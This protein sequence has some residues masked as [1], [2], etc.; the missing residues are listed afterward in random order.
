EIST[1]VPKFAR[2]LSAQYS[3]FNILS[4]LNSQLFES[5]ALMHISAVKSL[6]SALCQLSHQCMS[7]TSSGLGPTASQKLG[8]I[9]FSVE[10]MISILVNNVHRVEPFWDQVVSHFLELA[11]NPNPHLKN[12]ALDALDQS[13]SAVLGSNRFQNYKQLKSLQTSQEME[14][15]LDKLTSLECSIISPLK[16]LYFSTQSVDVRVGSLKILLHVLERYGEK[17][18]Y[19]WPNILE[20]LRYVADVSEKDLVTLGFQ[21]S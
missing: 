21:V 2:E 15:S 10:R 14:A 18:H 5:S 20:M 13:I 16:V 3:D 17:L 12:M 6:L 1:P 4:S 11:D 9:S 8:S 7:G 19:S